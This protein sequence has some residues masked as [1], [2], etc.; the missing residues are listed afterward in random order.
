[1]RYTITDEHGDVTREYQGFTRY[2][3]AT[4]L[5]L[6][7][8]AQLV[9]AWFDGEA[10]LWLVL[11]TEGEQALQRYYED[12]WGPGRTTFDVFL[13]RTTEAQLF[14]NALKG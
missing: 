12:D 7:P 11:G 6:H 10:D 1:M 8:G 9:V 13:R 2:T 4:C 5:A 14:G 3:G